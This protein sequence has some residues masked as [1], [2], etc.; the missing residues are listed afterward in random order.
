VYVGVHGPDGF[1]GTL[2]LLLTPVD[3]EVKRSQGA[4]EALP[5][6]VLVVRVVDNAGRDK[7]MRD[8]KED[9]RA[10]AEER[11]ERRV[12]DATDDALGLEVA[13]A[14]RESLRVRAAARISATGPT[15]SHTTKGAGAG[16]TTRRFD[17][18]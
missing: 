16:D 9:G 7:G 5:Q 8:L 13:I 2:R 1:A 10:A 4:E 12:A 15:S 3:D 6:V 14:A 17:D 18:P 11:Y